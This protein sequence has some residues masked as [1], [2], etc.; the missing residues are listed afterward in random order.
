ML[1]VRNEV[2]RK[3]QGIINLG[4]QKA[5]EVNEAKRTETRESRKH[6]NKFQD[7]I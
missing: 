4:D 5:S 7:L 2:S 6:C 1:E 3:R